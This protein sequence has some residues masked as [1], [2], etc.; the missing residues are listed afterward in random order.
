MVK[1][2][3]A[4]DE[5]GIIELIKQLIDV[6]GYEVAGEANNGLEALEKIKA[7]SPDVVITDI[8]MPLMNGIDLVKGVMEINPRTHFIVISG[9]RE[10][11]Y[12]K[13]ALQLGVQDYLLKPIKQ[14][15]LNQILLKIRMERE[16]EISRDNS[17]KQQYAQTLSVLRKDY[18]KRLF[19]DLSYFVEEVPVLDGKEVFRFEAGKFQCGIIKVDTE[20]YNLAEDNQVSV[21]LMELC[22]KVTERLRGVSS[23]AEYFISGNRG[24]FLMQYA[25]N[26]EEKDI[27]ACLEEI[28]DII[29]NLNFKFSFIRVTLGLSEKTRNRRSIRRIYKQAVS[30][31]EYR[32]DRMN[33]AVFVYQELYENGAVS[34]SAF[35][36][37]LKEKNFA[38]M[39]ERMDTEGI[40][41]TLDE[42]WK[43]YIY[44][45]K[46]SKNVPGQ[47]IQLIQYFMNE[48]H[49]EI[50]LML[51]IE[52]GGFS[53]YTRIMSIIDNHSDGRRLHQEILSYVRAC[54]E[55]CSQTIG[56]KESR[57][58]RMAKEYVLAHYMENFSLDDIARLVCL[59]PNYFSLLF[60][61]EV[62]QGFN[63]YLQIIRIEKAKELLKSTQMRVPDIAAAVGYSDIKYF[64]KLFIKVVGVKPTEY[65][66]F[67]S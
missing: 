34:K 16:D 31:I 29:I 4:D 62:G 20:E 37:W 41:R 66:K 52:L 28:K 6:D 40:V 2:F 57:P 9:Y 36:Q 44:P 42:M 45:A 5:Q 64:T 12:A 67:Y 43:K 25:D 30:A 23:E 54:M 13:S 56:E 33:E 60:K 10:F 24:F 51:G 18:I 22:G 61:N 19:H 49:N 55:Y 3:I 63:N 58:V 7:S 38:G 21:L 11:E 48:F 59:S 15:E 35:M 46:E 32:Y 39:V 8:R 1:I 47:T 53:Q 26:R 17:R 50:F 14:S 65:R 27:A